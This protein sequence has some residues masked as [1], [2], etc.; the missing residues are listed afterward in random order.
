LAVYNPDRNPLDWA[1]AQLNLGFALRSLAKREIARGD[2]DAGKARLE[3][4]I[5]AYR[6]ALSKY[7]PDNAGLSWA[8]TESN[9]GDALQGLY[10]SAGGLTFLDQAIDAFAKA[11]TL[12]TKDTSKYHW[13]TTYGQKGVALMLRAEQ[14]KNLTE[15]ENALRKIEVAKAAL[16]AGAYTFCAAPNGPQGECLLDA[17]YLEKRFIEGQK[18]RDIMMVK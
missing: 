18:I 6:D 7:T 8:S 14:T 4:S 12:Y 11:L 9:L 1:A 13:A 17:E 16:R 5:A 2:R 3:E 15:V 10:E